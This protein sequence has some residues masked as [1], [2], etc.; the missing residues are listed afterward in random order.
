MLISTF[1]TFTRLQSSGHL[2][3]HRFFLSHRFPVNLPKTSQLFFFPIPHFSA[4]W[5][6]VLSGDIKIC[7]ST[8]LS[9]GFKPPFCQIWGCCT[10]HL[11]SKQKVPNRWMWANSE[12]PPCFFAL[13]INMQLFFAHAKA[14][15]F[16]AFI[17]LFLIDGVCSFSSCHHN[18][19]RYSYFVCSSTKTGQ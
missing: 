10:N 14:T 4:I 16:E 3:F 1:F 7:P 5:A 8:F 15:P 17:Q 2:V 11:K 13:G 18:S 6:A 9:D 19:C 12:H